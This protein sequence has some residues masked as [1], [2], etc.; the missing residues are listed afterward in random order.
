MTKNNS[1]KNKTMEILA[2]VVICITPFGVWKIF[3]IIIC[4]LDKIRG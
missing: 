2:T 1:E 4:I 3:E